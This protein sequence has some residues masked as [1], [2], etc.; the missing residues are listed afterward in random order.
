MRS[1]RTM[2]LLHNAVKRAIVMNIP[3]RAS[4]FFVHE[5]GWEPHGFEGDAH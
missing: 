2:Q 3:R 5:R 4:R 1:S